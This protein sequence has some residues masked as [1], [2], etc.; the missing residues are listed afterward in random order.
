[1][2]QK[3]PNKIR[4]DERDGYIPIICIEADASFSAYGLDKGKR[5]L[6]LGP[7]KPDA[8]KLRYRLPNHTHQIEVATAKSTFWQ[9][10]ILYQPDGK[11]HLD[12][13]PIEIPAGF[14]QFP[15]PRS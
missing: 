4:I 7:F 8:R 11:E 2:L 15:A 5:D 13:T 9:I 6:L 12:P 3:G 1:M 10:S 14:N